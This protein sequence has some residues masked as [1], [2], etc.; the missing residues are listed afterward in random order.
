MECVIHILV[1]NQKA[2]VTYLGICAVFGDLG[3]PS[4]S[5]N[6]SFDDN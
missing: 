5:G 3:A 2:R 6:P 4:V 1:V